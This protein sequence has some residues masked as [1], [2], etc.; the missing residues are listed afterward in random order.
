MAIY[1]NDLGLVNALGCGK[2]DVL[3]NWLRNQAPS[4]QPRAE[5][6]PGK[7]VMLGSVTVPLISIDHAEFATRTSSLLLCA[8]QQLSATIDQMKTKYGA[9]RIGVVIGTSTSG[10]EEGE[11]Y[12]VAQ[13]RNENLASYRYR[14][15]EIGAP[16]LF[17]SKQLGVSGPCLTVSTACSSSAK[18]LATARNWL[19][20]NLCDVVIA[21]GAD[22]LC[23][24]TVNGFHALGLVS[25]E[26]CKPF[27]AARKG[28]NIG[29]AAALFVISREQS[30]VRLLA[31]GESS[32]AYHI[33]APHPE[34]EGAQRS[35]QAALQEAHL[36]TADI[37]YIN[38]HGTATPANDLAEAKSVAAL[39]GDGVA[40]SS[41]K[42]LTGHT[43]GAA[44]ATEAG[45]CWLLLQQLATVQKATLPAQAGTP[46]YEPALPATGFLL[47]NK[48]LSGKKKYAMLSNS[49]AFGGSNV[50]V[51]LGVEVAA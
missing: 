48:T 26:R 6:L 45:L 20:M 29:E 35:M 18:V 47:A 11:R 38:L 51:I 37:D 8:L 23:R 46:V 9:A 49:F 19:E 33:S 3:A 15:Q 25:E 12:I 31:V 34:G 30:P 24:L 41:T 7:S 32:D 42:S 14:Q 4:M 43:L 36:T 28:I 16:G 21:G 13:Q 1:L 2:Q 17:V 10:I 5:F 44:G 40:C 50:S 39:F 27:E 22:S